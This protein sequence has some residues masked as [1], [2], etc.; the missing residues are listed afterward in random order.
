MV[1][2][3]RYQ[4]NLKSSPRS[5]S[6]ANRSRATD[7]LSQCLSDFVNQLAPTREE[8]AIKEDV[9]KLLERLIRT[10]QP[11]SRLLA[12]GST[13]NGFSLRNSGKGVTNANGQL[14][15]PLGPLDMDLCCL[16]ETDAVHPSA[17]DMVQDLGT[18]LEK[19]SDEITSLCDAES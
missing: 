10:V 2:Q 13:A 11:Q 12:F 18:L 1:P 3:G 6:S 7:S 5:S 4:Q 8:V 16:I 17:S 19:G 15:N 9:R 14:L